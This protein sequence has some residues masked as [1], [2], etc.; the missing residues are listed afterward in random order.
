M[1]LSE[2]C[3]EELQH[4]CQGDERCNQESH[5]LLFQMSESSQKLFNI[6]I[7]ILG[8]LALEAH[9]L[10][11][12]VPEL[13]T[14]CTDSLQASTLVISLLHQTVLDWLY[15][16]LGGLN[17][18]AATVVKLLVTFNRYLLNNFNEQDYWTRLL[19]KILCLNI[20]V[21][22]VCDVWLLRPYVW[23][24]RRRLMKKG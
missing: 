11:S 14:V 16:Q 22:F 2:G 9:G 18:T 20:K 13:Q 6:L 21:V 15:C 7:F 24:R 5:P 4:D 1:L 8:R 23:W 10:P 17:L 12:E 19:N 3:H